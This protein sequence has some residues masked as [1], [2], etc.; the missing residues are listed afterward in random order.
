MPKVKGKKLL[1]SCEKKYFKSLQGFGEHSL[2]DRFSDI[3]NTI[4]K[5]INEDY[6]HFLAQPILE[7]DETIF[8]FGHPYKETPKRLTELQEEMRTHYEQIK[9]DT[10]THFRTV[11][12]KL[13]QEQKIRKAESLE[14]AI[15]FVNDDFVYCYDNKI[16][17]GIWGMQL[18][19]EVRESLGVVMKTQYVSKKNTIEDVSE[20]V[21]LSEDNS[22][23]Q[24]ETIDSFTIYFNTGEEGNIIGNS[25]LIKLENQAI[26]QSEIPEIKAKDGYEFI[27]WDRKIDNF[28][29]TGDTVFTAQYRE[30][31]PP[32]LPPVL[33]WYKRYNWLRWLLW[34]LLLLLLLLLFCWLCRSCSDTN[35]DPNLSSP[36]IDKPEIVEDPN[37]D[38][39]GI[40]N[41]GEPYQS[42]P[43][44]PEYLD[45]LPPEEGVLEPID[46][47]EIIREPGKPVIIGNRLNI[48]MEN[49]E[50]SIIDFAK[51]FKIK[52]PDNKY[53][54]VYYDDVV[55]RM[56]IKVPVEEREEFKQTIPS[57][58]APEYEL[59]VFDEALFESRY[60]PN[61]PAFN[62]PDTSWYFNAIN[63][64]KAWDLT[65]GS[66]DITI[67]I[68]DNG[69]SLNHPEFNDKVVMPYNVWTHS[70]DIFAQDVD[71][72]THV[73]GTALAIMDNK[74]GNCG[75]APNS[76]FMP[77]QIA[78]NQNIMTTT[79][80]LDG[81][82]YALYQGADVINIS[83]GT[84]FEGTLPESEQQDLQ[85][86]HFKEEE[87]LWKEVMKIANQHKSIIVIAAGNDNMLA[88]VDPLNR[89]KHFITV[90]AVDRNLEELDRA[91]FSNYGDFSTVSAPGVNIFSTVGNDEYAI[92][93]GTSM[94]APIIS[95]AV[96]LMKSLNRDITAEEIICV[97]QNTGKVS[98]GEIGKMVQLDK[99]LEEVQSN[100]FKSCVS[101]PEKPSTG[102][103]Q[104][105]LSWDNYNDLDIHCI[106]PNGDKVWYKNKTVPS[107]GK[108]E[109]DMNAGGSHSKSPIENIYWPTNGAPDG[110]YKVY[111]NFFKKK[112]PNINNSPY[113]ITVKYGDS[114]KT[115]NGTISE[116]G[117]L[118]HILTFSLGTANNTD[119]PQNSNEPSTPETLKDLERKR[120]ELQRQLEE[121]D[122]QLRE[123][124]GG[125][126][127]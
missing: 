36:L 32:P 12:K 11:I 105:L 100:D 2:F 72:G 121:I 109:I 90:S 42:E 38:N 91:G 50:K 88:G 96:A 9:A 98:D 58:F 21:P 120:K 127:N 27:G 1:C 13:R 4:K 101:Q 97:F 86:N 5:N 119:L 103:V 99:A 93:D 107:G 33:P 30:V 29:V 59:F 76:M 39:G 124:Q 106:D 56:Q 122:R 40:Y 89:P 65:L 73:A 71:H 46:S 66:S 83:L 78:N 20:G 7:S 3:E 43:T 85:N 67:A 18:R 15:K 62:D 116:E 74:K 113:T 61:D 48:L 34:L 102:D 53:E 54:V 55:K 49:K 24:T 23:T 26:S 70:D 81:V 94:A 17:L 19:D 69:F 57:L 123:L 115:L 117:E 112:A 45:V 28:N 64:S 31:P 111:L 77:V 6:Q 126:P 47:T 51:D 82:L 14:K 10:I 44:P 22:S 104:V 8:W 95:G 68:V 16:V 114:T 60:N 41:P 87:R 110:T 52:F 84:E 35:S 75:I 79:S 25:E 63:A 92:M 108:L 80:V 37:S 118:R 125:E